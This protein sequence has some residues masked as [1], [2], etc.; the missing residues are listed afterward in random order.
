MAQNGAAFGITFLDK[1]KYIWK[2][3]PGQRYLGL[4]AYLVRNVS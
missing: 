3:L 2:K 4:G 1:E